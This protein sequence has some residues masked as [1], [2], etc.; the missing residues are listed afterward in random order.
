MRATGGTRA[1][2][3]GLAY[4][5]AGLLTVAGVAHFLAPE[6]FTEIVPEALPLRRELVYVSGV[7]E[8]A[9]AAL[10]V[11]PRTRRTGA[12]MTTALLVL[13]FPA[14]VQMALDRGGI[15]W[16]RLPLQAPLILWALAI[17]RTSGRGR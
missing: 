15:W 5:L 13:V 4:G 8:L 7:A 17:R 2:G 6:P 11:H 16:W 3:R 10:L 9:C 1:A 14:N 12:L